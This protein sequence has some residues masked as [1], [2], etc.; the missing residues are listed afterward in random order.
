MEQLRDLL[1][2]LM[3]YHIEVQRLR[4][5]HGKRMQRRYFRLAAPS[6]LVE[7]CI[8]DRDRGLTRQGAQKFDLVVVEGVFLFCVKGDESKQLILSDKRNTE[9][10]D[11][12]EA[13]CELA[14]IV[15]RIG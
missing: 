2:R 5:C 8:L 9:I 15:A 13:L 12:T 10:G 6:L 4:G 3:K 1:D 11:Q 7:L 14:F